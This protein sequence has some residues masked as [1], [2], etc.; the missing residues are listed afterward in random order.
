LDSRGTARCLA[1][2]TIVNRINVAAALA[3]LLIVPDI[4]YADEADDVRAA[5]S[6]IKSFISICAQSVP[7]LVSVEASAKRLGWK[8]SN[9]DTGLAPTN[10]NAESKSWLVESAAEVPFDLNVSRLVEGEQITSICSVANPE[11]PLALIKSELTKQLH[12]EQ[13]IGIYNDPKQGTTYW[14]I[15]IR[16]SDIFISLTEGSPI[17]EPGIIVRAS[18]VQNPSLTR[19]VFG[20]AKS[21][22][23]GLP[24]WI[25][26]GYM[27]ALSTI[28]IAGFFVFP[29]A[30]LAFVHRTFPRSSLVLKS[31]IFVISFT[32]WGFF[33]LGLRWMTGFPFWLVWIGL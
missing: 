32:C 33:I 25:L 9:E 20:E 11:A 5:G 3:I 18:V 29:G 16:D 19:L 12:L 30:V 23:S 1:G 26:S 22:I 7:N 31:L 24:T 28:S 17:N 13:P 2:T 10:K 27:D 4:A 21:I 8:E 6:L 14:Q 15:T